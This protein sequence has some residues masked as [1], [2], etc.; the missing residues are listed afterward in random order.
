MTTMYV[1]TKYK[2]LNIT[3]SVHLESE[4]SALTIGYMI[5]GKLPTFIY[6]NRE[7]TIVHSLRVFVGIK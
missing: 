7:I 6:K 3:K 5:L 2:N 1:S 4:L